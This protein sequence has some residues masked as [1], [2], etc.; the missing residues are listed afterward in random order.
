MPL[1]S[2]LAIGLVFSSVIL[3]AQPANNTTTTPKQRTLPSIGRV[4]GKVIET[5]TKQPV[6]FATVTLLAMQKDSVINGCLAK[7]NGD[8]SLDKLPF[9]RFRLKISFIGYKPL[10]KQV[11]IA[12]NN[13]EQDLGDIALDVDSKSLN[14]ALI[15]GEKATVVMAVDRRIYNVDKDIS[16]KGGTG[17]DAIKNIPGLTVD[18]DG[19]VN[20]RNSSPT[21]F[22][23]GRPTTL[24]LEQIPADD[25]DRVEVIT[26]PSAKFDASTSGGI[27]NIVLKKN[28][29]PG[30]N[31]MITFG[32]GFPLRYN[33]MANL[34]IKEGRSN[35]GLSYNLNSSLNP[36]KG[37][38]NRTN[39]NNDV[40]TGYF[41]QNNT[42]DAERLMQNGRLSFDYNI[43]NR[44]TITLAQGFM[45]GGFDTK[46]TQDFEQLGTG[47]N[48]ISSGR[49]D[50]IQENKWQNYSSQMLF[51]KTFPRQGKEFT[52]DIN[53]NRSERKNNADFYTYNYD[54]INQLIFPGEEQQR[55]RG[56]GNSQH[57]TFQFDFVNPVTDTAK[58]EFGL[59]SNIKTDDTYLN[60]DNRDNIS[61]L[62]FA[63]SSLT[64]SYKIND[65]V[66]AAYVTYS[67]AMFGVNYQAGMRLEQTRFVG[68]LVGK[69]QTFEY[70]YPN[71]AKNIAKAIFPSLYLTKRIGEKHEMQLN[72]SRKINRPG[73]MQVMPFIMFADKLNYRIGNPN[74]APEFTNSVEFNYNRI[75]PKGN[76]FVATYFKLTEDPIT[77][78]TQQLTSDT[79]G[80]VLLNTFIN[81]NNMFNYGVES[82]YKISLLKRKLDVTVNAN[83]FYTDISATTAISTLKN[84]GLSWNGKLVASYKLPKQFTL[85]AN[86]NYEAPRIIPQG[87]TL[88]Q[89]SIDISLNKEIT[90]LLSFNVVLNDVFNTRRFGSTF[91]SDYLLQD[92]SRRRE[93]RF[94]RVGVTWRF[95]EMDASLFKK[96]ANRRSEGGNMEMDF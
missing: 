67:N 81:G 84:S 38:T 16:A 75:L 42:T 41:N 86:G 33:G 83:V 92:I 18:A 15:Q 62:F 71:G 1:K 72:F 61:G 24:T 12:P 66:N 78:F 11:V 36:T 54:S 27:L 52:T 79:T 77:N 37:Y 29:K 6:E 82:N 63:D 28:T 73:F 5:G 39:L 93:T 94:L 22:V 80:N 21:I 45:S 64:N 69:N 32:A 58:W 53:Y 68:E 88:N 40:A 8:F 10:I 7:A 85:Q 87:K 3:F 91:E 34:N 9:G 55:N 17:I 2:L 74:L 50:A 19:G 57:I 35:F 90:K 95:G 76:L 51:R 49:R 43:T 30:Y 48:T 20:M 60:V 25:I 44:S 14:E 59:R 70:L 26:N 46:E 23:D 13:M 96:R 56:G 31:G 47:K 4:Y 65:M 89:Y